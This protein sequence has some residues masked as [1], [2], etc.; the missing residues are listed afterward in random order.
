MDSPAVWAFIWLAVA[1]SFGV[2]EILL[3]GSFFLVP[4]AVGAL[5]ASIVSFLGAPVLVGWVLF[6]VVSIA[7]FLALKP[8]AKRLDKALP[9]PIGIGANRLIGAQGQVHAD[10]PRGSNNTGLIRVGGEEWLAE[11]RDG[12]GVPSGTQVRVLEVRGTRVIVEPADQTGIPG[13]S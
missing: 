1:A 7:V 12:M 5:V 11:G 9:N 6:I 3:A 8:L 10:I 4:F 13:L 2:G